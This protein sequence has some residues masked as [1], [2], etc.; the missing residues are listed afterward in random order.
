MLTPITVTVV[1]AILHPEMLWSLSL[2]CES[3]LLYKLVKYN[4]FKNIY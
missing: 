4:Y 3:L 2:A 1:N